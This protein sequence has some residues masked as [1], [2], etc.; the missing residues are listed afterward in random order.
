MASA[1]SQQTPELFEVKI[2]LDRAEEAA[3]LDRARK[4]SEDDINTI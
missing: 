3:I 1:I 2:S 4:Y